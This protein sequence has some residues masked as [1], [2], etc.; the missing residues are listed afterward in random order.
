[1]FPLRGVSSSQFS[2]QANSYSLFHYV[3]LVLLTVQNATIVILMS[4]TQQRQSSKDPSNRF[5]TSHVVMMTEMVKFLMS[6]AWCAWDVF[7]TIAPRGS[8]VLDDSGTN[9][10]ETPLGHR[11]SDVMRDVKTLKQDQKLLCYEDSHEDNSNGAKLATDMESAP[12][13]LSSDAQSIEV[14]IN[15][16]SFCGLFLLQLLHRSAVPTAVPA[17]IYAFQN[18]VMFVALANME[19]TL[20][21]VTYQTKILGTALLL[22]IFLGRTFSSQQWMALFLLMAGVV[23]AQLGSKHSNRKPEEKTN[24]VEIS[25]SYVVGVVATTMAVLCSS[26]G[27]VMSEWLFKS[28]D[29]SLSSHTSTKNVHLSAYSVVCYIVAQLLAG[30]GSNTQGQAQVNATPDDVNAGTSF[31]QEYFRGFDSLVWLM[32]FVQA[33]GGLLVALVIKHT[34]NIMKAF[35]AGCSIVLSGILSLLIYSFVPGILFVIGSMLC[36]VALIIYSRG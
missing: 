5:N 22:W 12:A 23:L 8:R 15:R 28:K 9:A 19:P 13:D 7:S 3:L 2:S 20:F 34:D 16:E 18:Y 25:G 6:L 24:S 11:G 31:F 36:I 27:A 30:S 32:I 21:Q 26:A 14:E 10:S 33:V 29:A 17:I 35:A 1:M 4:Y